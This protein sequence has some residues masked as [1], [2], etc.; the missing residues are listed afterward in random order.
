MWP[1]TMRPRR[2]RVIGRR[3]VRARHDVFGVAA[4]V[5]GKPRPHRRL[6]IAIGPFP[7]MHHP[8]T[9]LVR[10]TGSTRARVVSRSRARVALVLTR[11]LVSEFFREKSSS[12]ARRDRPST[13]STTRRRGDGDHRVTTARARDRRHRHASTSR[14]P[15]DGDAG[16]RR[17]RH[18]THPHNPPV[19][20]HTIQ[21]VHREGT[22]TPINRQKKH[23]G[24]PFLSIARGS[25]SGTRR[26]SRGSFIHRCFLIA[27]RPTSP[28]A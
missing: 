1:T 19:V 27:I 16:T 25:D 22:H 17:R 23:H 20:T 12:R 9:P 7:S 21:Y 4:R 8:T 15:T 18:R 13:T 26:A 3:R 11:A 28:N 10:L 5:R 6:R 24:R 2:A 14:A